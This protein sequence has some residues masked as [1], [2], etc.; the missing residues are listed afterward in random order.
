MAVALAL[1]FVSIDASALALGR[2][3]VQSA[4]GEPLRAEINVTDIS[5]AEAEGLKISIGSPESYKTSGMP[6]ST[7]LAG[8]SVSLQTR[9][10][11]SYV[12]LL[13]S[14]KSM[15][16]PFIDLL[17]EANWSSG[18][19]VREY[20]VLLDP[21]LARQASSPV[22]STA[23]QISST[24]LL[25]STLQ[26]APIIR[27]AAPAIAAAPVAPIPRQR[28][29]TVSRAESSAV[30]PGPGEQI[31]V[32]RG[33]TAS[34]IAVSYKPADVSL[35]QML[36]ALLRGNTDAFIGGNIN[37]MKSGAVLAL[38]SD[39]QIRA[40]TPT[41]AAHIVKAQSTD[42]GDYRRRLAYNAPVSRTNAS[43]R[44]A[45]GKLQASVEERNAAATSPDKLKISQGGSTA[46]AADNNLAQSR[47]AQ[48]TNDRATELAKN[49]DELKKLQSASESVTVP[50]A[51]ASTPT[52]SGIP[53][54]LAA[55]IVPIVSA[56]AET[57]AAA[58]APASLASAS[59]K[60]KV[61]VADAVVAPESGF[62][63]GLLSNPLMLGAAALIAALIA[64]LLYR[65]LGRRRPSSADSVFF[66][67]KMPR[68]SFFG[69]SG[70]RQVDTNDRH[71]SV[72]SSLSYSPSQLDSSDVDPVAE[73][74]V[75]L[76]YGRDLQAEEILR[77]AM[78][79]HPERVAPFLKLLEIHA[80]RRD[81]RAF[82]AL[83]NDINKLTGG[84]GPEWARA[85]ELGRDMNKGNRLNQADVLTA[86]A[87]APTISTP[88]S[89]A[90]VSPV[91]PETQP[92][93]PQFV[94]SVAPLDFDLDMPSASR[95]EVAP[96]PK[97][98]VDVDAPLDTLSSPLQIIQPTA[99]GFEFDMNWL[100]KHHTPGV[101]DTQ[102]SHLASTE[103]PNE[104][105]HAVK[106]SL[107][108][109][110]QS[111]G[112]AEGARSLIREVASEGSGELQIKAKQLLAQLAN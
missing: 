45:S 111:I 25:R 101:P 60:P 64:F 20:T 90:S 93:S 57:T 84:T 44:Q 26:A 50:V 91:E 69:V 71:S 4:L 97:T 61:T 63:T 77:E 42:F 30:S 22:N 70:G 99:S 7:F 104:H 17:L 51:S 8:V 33:D 53:A 82:E 100:S 92:P 65:V 2:L 14:S 34:K 105:P 23:P 36:V 11:G 43:D 27:N 9:A 28:S 98:S 19:I 54:V 96:A 107:A 10:D 5:V 103:D 46:M 76:A 66:E 24:P 86:T 74:D 102:P 72:V 16:D 56:A 88:L 83:T 89:P 15:N 112:D 13:N 55:P 18:R 62:I 32:Q 94:H 52:I 49:L 40:A 12:V 59:T 108:R 38:P 31:T 67:S 79:T 48:V 109:E 85:V 95:H 35:D 110:L 1:S 6:Y 78:R 81:L 68:D 73:A 58:S 29:A 106:L 37:R 87:T 47:Q 41:E 3:N 39:S 80:K 21:P 75:Y